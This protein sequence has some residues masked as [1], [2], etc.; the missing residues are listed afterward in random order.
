MARVIN[1][2]EKQQ[3][4]FDQSYKVQI[5][6][7]VIYGLGGGHTHIHTHMKVISS[8]QVQ[9]GC[10]KSQKYKM[11]IHRDD[12]DYQDVGFFIIL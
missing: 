6:P 8:D 11:I 2:T 9:W 5:T 7:L 1:Q 10:L 3:E 4:L 12:M